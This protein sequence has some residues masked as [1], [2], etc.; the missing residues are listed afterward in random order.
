MELDI[1]DLVPEPGKFT[2][3]KYGGKP[4]VVKLRP[5]SLADEIHINKKY[6]DRIQEIFEKLMTRELCEIA[7][8]LCD[9]KEVFERKEVTFFS[10]EGLKFKKHVGGIELMMVLVTGID[11]KMKMIEALLATI[12]ISRPVMDKLAGVKKKLTGARS[13]T[14]SRTSTA[15][16]QSRS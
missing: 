5:I 13:S 14:Y 6:G 3:K 8:H 7:Y 15:G 9:N 10:D 1:N 4:I 12:G 16:R 2:L 11:E